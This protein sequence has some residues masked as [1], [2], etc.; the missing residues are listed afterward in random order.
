MDYSLLTGPKHLDFAVRPV[1]RPFDRLPIGG[2]IEKS[3]PRRVVAPTHDSAR[4]E[5]QAHL[6]DDF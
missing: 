4:R 6:F 3:H 1:G 5:M 2:P